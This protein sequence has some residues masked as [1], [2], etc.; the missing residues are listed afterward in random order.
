[1]KSVAEEPNPKGALNM[2]DKPIPP[3]KVNYPVP[4]KAHPKSR[5]Y[6]E[7]LLKS[8]ATRNLISM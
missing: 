7:A 4:E 1:M 8:M 2:P 6:R 3:G 5:M